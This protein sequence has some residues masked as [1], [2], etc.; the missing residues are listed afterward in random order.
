MQP[1]F[2]RLLV[3]NT[4]CFRLSMSICDHDNF[5]DS[6]TESLVFCNLGSDLTGCATYD[7]RSPEDK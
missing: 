1:K 4:L 7:S 6:F 2:L 5:A 3:L